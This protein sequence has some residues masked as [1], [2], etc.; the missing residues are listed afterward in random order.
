MLSLHKYKA[1]K[2]ERSF[3]VRKLNDN[4]YEGLAPLLKPHVLSRGVFGGNLC[5]S[6]MVAAMEDCPGFTPHSLH[7]YFV[8]AGDDSAVCQ[9]EIE[10]LNDGKSF[11]NRL[12]RVIQNSELKYI[13]MVSLTAK[14]DKK[15]QGLDYQAPV[16]S[17]FY[18]YNPAE[19]TVHTLF[20]YGGLLQHKIPPNFQQMDPKQAAISAGER[21]LLFWIRIGD[22]DRPQVSSKF[23]YAGIGVISDS[24]YLSAVSRLL[25][26]PYL[27]QDPHN[28]TKKIPSVLITG[29]KN[30]YF[31]GVSL[32]HLV[33]IHDDAFDPHDW[34]FVSFRAPR[35]VNNRVLMNASYYDKK[36]K[37]FASV[38]QEGL[39]YFHLGSE[40][41]AKL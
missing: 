9:F 15:K 5:A 40:R 4:R 1:S 29:G 28:P 6:A 20:D 17:S 41:R 32:D 11:K 33:F 10:R 37:L 22:E 34:I 21:E 19:L 23:R 2:L 36:G 3:A 35:M 31:F 24:I 13:V 38:V 39:V 18:K 26:L 12:V 8:K 25:D 7:L 30:S 16:N 27:G 14:T